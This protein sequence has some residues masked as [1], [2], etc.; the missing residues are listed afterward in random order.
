MNK[1]LRFGILLSLSL[2]M[3][4]CSCK[5]KVIENEIESITQEV[6]NCINNEMKNILEKH[7]NDD[8]ADTSY[9]LEEANELTN[10]SEDISNQ[11]TSS[12][13]IK[14]LYTD[15]NDN[16]KDE[17]ENLKQKN[18]DIELI[19]KMMKGETYSV[20]DYP[21]D[22]PVFIEIET[23]QL[24]NSSLRKPKNAISITIPNYI[25]ALMTSCISGACSASWI[26]FIGWAV[27]AALI[28]ALIVVIAANWDVIKRK[29]DDIKS[30]FMTKFARIGTLI[31]SA[32]TKAK[33]E[34]QK[35]VYFP[36]NPSSFNPFGLRRE[37]Y[38]GGGNG[39]IWKWFEV[40][41]MIFEWDEDYKVGRHYHILSYN[42]NHY[43]PNSEVP[44]PYATRYF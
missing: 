12:E 10:Q 2:L 37:K 16:V 30:Y 42:G 24:L 36:Y 19:C 29:F 26:P 15:L 3:T 22:T 13:I 41:T 28:V 9:I 1:K 27:A 38:S 21:T 14:D 23:N 11:E 34:N 33:E 40:N 8:N 31:D 6:E 44:E 4:G 5:Y 7:Y 39:Q 32:M 43:W 25:L 17:I 20:D 35:K 18:S